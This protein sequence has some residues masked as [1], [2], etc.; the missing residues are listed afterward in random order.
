MSVTRNDHLFTQQSK[1]YLEQMELLARRNLELFNY[2]LDLKDG[3][4]RM[5][6]AAGHPDAKEGGRIVCEE[7][8]KLLALKVS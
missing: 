3:I 1:M 2:T 5:I 7:G 6:A 8:K 4:Q